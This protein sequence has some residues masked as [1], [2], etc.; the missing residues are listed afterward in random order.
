MTLYTIVYASIIPPLLPQRDTQATKGD[1]MD[2][3]TTWPKMPFYIQSSIDGS[4]YALTAQSGDEQPR[5][6]RTAPLQAPIDFAWS[7]SADQ[8]GGAHLQHIGT[9]LYLTRNGEELQ[10]EQLDMGKADQL[11][12]VE[13]LGSPWVGINAWKNWE[14]KINVYDSDVNGIIGLY[15]WCGGADNEKWMLVQET[16]AVT[17]KS[18]DYNLDEAT[19]S[20]NLTPKVLYSESFDNTKSATEFEQT[21]TINKSITRSRALSLSESTTVESR[22]AMTLGVSGGFMDFFSVNSDFSFEKSTSTTKSVTDESTETTTD[23]YDIMMS[24]RVPAGKLYRYSVIVY[25]AQFQIPFTATMEFKS[26]VL[27][28]SPITF[29]VDG[30]YEGVNGIRAEVEVTEVSAPNSEPTV[31]TRIPVEMTKVAETEPA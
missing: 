30:I 17:V 3:E 13:D 10:L 14:Q 9:G 25:N 26:K 21:F 28:S 15:N 18:V 4:N 27:G 19:K 12:R 6:V 20:L 23:T 31:T 7:A 16:S 22:Y 11:W 1:A 8:R 2:N 5:G 29:T 24:V